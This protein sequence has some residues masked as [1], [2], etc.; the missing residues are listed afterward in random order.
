MIADGESSQTDELTDDCEI[1]DFLESWSLCLIDRMLVEIFTTT[2]RVA[3]ITVA[4]AVPPQRTLN[5]ASGFPSHPEP[6]I[7]MPM[8]EAIIPMIRIA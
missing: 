3:Q 4:K 7:Y 6:R 8:T 2:I 5:A 1:G